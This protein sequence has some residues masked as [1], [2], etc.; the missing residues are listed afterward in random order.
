MPLHSALPTAPLHTQVLLGKALSRAFQAGAAA[1]SDEH[2]ALGEA[3]QENVR[4]VNSRGDLPPEMAAE[5]ER[6]WVWMRV[7][8]SVNAD[9]GRCGWR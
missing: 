8:A 4:V 9:A 6:R 7:W 3:E 2:R 1:L 5:Y